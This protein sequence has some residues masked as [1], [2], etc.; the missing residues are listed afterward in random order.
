MKCEIIFMI[1]TLFWVVLAVTLIVKSNSKN[2]E[3]V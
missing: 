3:M 2:D 1:S